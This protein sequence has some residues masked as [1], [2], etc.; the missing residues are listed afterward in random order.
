HEDNTQYGREMGDAFHDEAR[1]VVKGKT[2][3]EAAEAL[4]K[5]LNVILVPFPLN[6]SRLRSTVQTD[7]SDPGGM[8]GLPSHLRPLSMDATANRS[9][10][11][12]QFTPKTTASYTELALSRSLQ[13]IRREGIGTVVLLATDPRDK[14]FLARQIARESPNVAIVTAESDSFYVHPDYSSYMKGTISVSTYPLY[15]ADQHWSSAIP[16][17][18]SEWRQFAN[19]SAQGVYNATLALLEF[20]V[21]GMPLR[22]HDVPR[23]LNYGMRGQTCFSACE[24]PIWINVVGTT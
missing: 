8:F 24:P 23:L 20:D 12:P 19:A 14:L 15:D 9:D 10:Q 11:V 18:P 22:T 5:R 17:A 7:A 6:I 21:K 4:L 1:K 13:T 2:Q 16:G 3:D